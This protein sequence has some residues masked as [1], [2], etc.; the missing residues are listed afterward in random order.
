MAPN[1]QRTVDTSKTTLQRLAALTGTH[2]AL[3]QKRLALEQKFKGSVEQLP[4]VF[5]VSEPSVEYI[6]RRNKDKSSSLV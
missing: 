1:L 3:S 4:G 5:F 6:Q 2:N